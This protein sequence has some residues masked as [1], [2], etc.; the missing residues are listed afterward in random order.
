MRVGVLALQG[1][2]QAAADALEL[3]P[4]VSTVFVRQSVHLQNCDALWLPGGESTT[5][6]SLLQRDPDLQHALADFVKQKPTFAVCA[7][8]ILAAKL[9]GL[10]ADISRNHFGRQSKT[11]V[12]QLRLHTP[13]GLELSD[14]QLFV[15]APAILSVGEG[16]EVLAE[17]V[18]TGMAVAC[19]SGHILATAFHPELACDDVSWISYFLRNVCGQ[20][21]LPAHVE[22]P[23]ATLRA[24]WTSDPEVARKRAFHIFQ[25]GGVIMDVVTPEQAKVAEKAGAV[26]VMALEKIPADIKRDGGVA[27]SSDPEMI[28]GILDVSS[29]PVYAKARIGHFAEAQILEALDCDGIDESEVLTAADSVH[30]IDK[31]PLNIPVVCGC[32]DLGEA[33]RRIAEGASFIRVKGNAGTGNVVHAVEHARRLFGEINALMTMPAEEMFVKAKELRVSVELLEQTRKL[34]RLPVVTFAA[35]GLATPADVALLMQMG[36]DG[37]FVGSGIFKADG[38]PY[39]RAKAMVDACTHH[40]R[41]LVVANASRGLG[42]AMVGILDQGESYKTTNMDAKL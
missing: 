32:R 13:S 39:H 9:F 11:R 18:D 1:G 22:I 26:A 16:V 37:V 10:S 7:G 6:E 31:R 29:I 35:G 42:K 27:R 40:R 8:M 5:L 23:A 36:M 28:Q 34:G 24:P 20:S 19:R 12:R 21:Q 2:F 33:L 41:P 4:G 3:F 15:R 14:R 25:Q 38:D 17:D 30:H